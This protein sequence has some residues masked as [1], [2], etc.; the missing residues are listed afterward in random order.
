MPIR[1]LP[2]PFHASGDEKSD[3]N[4]NEKTIV[5]PS[6]SS[7]ERLGRNEMYCIYLCDK[8]ETVCIMGTPDA[9]CI[10]DTNR[11]SSTSLD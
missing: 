6:F 10:N 7:I 11:P 8:D 9:D 4:D 1:V 2:A 3:G 5:P